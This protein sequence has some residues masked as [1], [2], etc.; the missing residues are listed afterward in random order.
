MVQRL[1]EKAMPIESG[2]KEPGQ[3]QKKT[4]DEETQRLGG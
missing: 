4:V 1:K 2:K 3:N